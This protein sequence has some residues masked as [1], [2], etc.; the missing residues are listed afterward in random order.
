MLLTG[1]L[2]YKLTPVLMQSRKTVLAQWDSYLVKQ[3][4][5]MLPTTA[6]S[7]DSSLAWHAVQERSVRVNVTE[8]YFQASNS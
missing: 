7:A 2:P 4:L 5:T 6:N 8:P 3:A 1:V